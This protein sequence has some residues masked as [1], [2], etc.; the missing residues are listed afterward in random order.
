MHSRFGFAALCLLTLGVAAC[1]HGRTH[2]PRETPTPHATSTFEDPPQNTPT[3]Q[4]T[5]TFQDPPQGTPPPPPPPT[6][7]P[8]STPTPRATSKPA[9]T[10]APRATPVV[11]GA[12]ATEVV[13]KVIAEHRSE[14]G[15]CGGAHPGGGKVML[16]FTVTGDVLASVDVVST[17]ASAELVAC[18][19]AAARTW[20]FPA[21]PGGGTAAFT[22]PFR[23]AEPVDDPEEARR[24]AEARRREEEMR[25]AQMRAS[26]DEARLAMMEAERLRLAEAQAVSASA[27]NVV[28]R[29]PFLEAPDEVA[30]GREFALQVSLTMADYKPTNVEIL[31]GEV[32]TSGALAMSLP[33][34]VENKGWEMEVVLS[35]PGFTIRDGKNTAKIQLPVRG[36][37]TPAMFKLTARKTAAPREER[38]A[39]ASIWHDGTFLAKVAARIEVVAELPVPIEAQ[40]RESSRAVTEMF[41]EEEQRT[42]EVERRQSAPL[43][44]ALLAS[45]L[46]VLISGED[47][48]IA[49]PHLVP[50]LQ[51]YKLKR[52]EGLPE[53]LASW[54][55][56]FARSVPRGGIAL[57]AKKKEATGKEATIA[58]LEGFGLEAWRRFAPPQFRDA[59]WSLEDKLGKEF[60]TLQIV[61]DD[62]SLPWELM[63]PSREKGAPLEFL[64]VK[65][66]I[67]RWHASEGGAFQ[68]ARPP[69]VAEL[70]TVTVIAPDY[71]GTASAL[72]AQA[73]EVIALKTIRGYREGEGNF[74]GVKGVFDDQPSGI[75]HFAG[76]GVVHKDGNGVPEY[77]VVLED[78]ELNLMM[79][80]GLMNGTLRQHPFFFFNACDL[81]QAEK[82]AGFVD[83][84]APAVLDAG[85]GGYIGGLWPLGDRAAA[86]AAGQFYKSL[87]ARLAAGETASVA[88]ILQE[89]RRRFYET[90]DPT[91]LAYV[92]Y[93][94]PH[95]RFRAVAP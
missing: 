28:A 41:A 87:G 82:V 39:F 85:A 72:P 60:R 59:F 69:Q 56:R 70:R 38:R 74:S 83:G 48:V 29:F 23:F 9:N 42:V 19:V 1:P 27:Q 47:M 67:A 49:S 91:Y 58:K 16:R 15:E 53:F 63:R 45:D 33:A 75:V 61:T 64:G 93:G 62:P 31:Q 52:P 18:V 46:T 88:S 24:L 95:F 90:G 79:W 6:Q 44:D 71:G 34:P 8:T 80:R 50:T 77:A 10:S 20:K 89:T 3:P 12:L 26:S 22:F 94:D 7:A 17:D 55:G 43:P 36:D 51:S 4:A 54:Y 40:A 32:T 86:D 78:G 35:A 57:G 25:E 30:P 92:Y 66:Q 21:P 2:L 84:W 65:L 14:L 13:K 5:S 81:G 68:L 11:S 73:D 76:H 37:S